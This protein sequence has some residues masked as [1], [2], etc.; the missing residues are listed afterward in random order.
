MN[1]FIEAAATTLISVGDTLQERGSQYAD[2]WGEQG[3]WHLTRAIIQKELGATVS[4]ETCRNIALASFI[5]QKY[6]RYAG[7]FKQDTTID[8]IGYLAALSS[9]VN[10]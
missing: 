8:L 3:C 2:T 7:G 10:K 4:D 6:S 5:D 9:F 1:S